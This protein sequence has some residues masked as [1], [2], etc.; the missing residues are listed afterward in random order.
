[1]IYINEYNNQYYIWK[2]SYKTLLGLWI[3]LLIHET[4]T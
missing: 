4:K 1:M 2:S 3:N